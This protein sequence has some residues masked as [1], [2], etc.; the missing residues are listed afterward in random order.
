VLAQ[1]PCD[2]ARP[3]IHRA[4]SGV[5]DHEPDSFT[6]KKFMRARLRDGGHDYTAKQKNDGRNTFFHKASIIMYQLP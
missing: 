4:A 2:E 5:T 1:V 3:V 6:F